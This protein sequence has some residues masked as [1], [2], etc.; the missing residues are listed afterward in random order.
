MIVV[1]AWSIHL[2]DKLKE[3]KYSI[4]TS[5]QQTQIFGF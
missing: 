4:F 3:I 5:M 1:H 2:L